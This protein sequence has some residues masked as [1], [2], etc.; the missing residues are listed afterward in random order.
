M[1]NKIRYGLKKCYYAPLS[2]SAQG[3]ISWGTPVALPG[4]KSITHSPAGENSVEYA[5]DI[6]YFE[7]NGNNGYEGTLELMLI[8]EDFKKDCLGMTRSANGILVESA[9]D[10]LSP[11]ALMFEFTG[12]ANAVRHCFWKCIASRPNIDG[13]TK[14]ETITAATE[15]IP[16]KA[17]PVGDTMKVHG[18]CDDTTATA[19]SGWYTAV[20]EP[21]A[22]AGGSGGSGSSN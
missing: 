19:Y 18:S 7:V 3:V 6:A 8:P 2:V 11:F 12:D 10:V 22:A 15:S 1:A 5:D 17:Y 14:G 4:A 13:E 21:T 16:F 9:N 20:P